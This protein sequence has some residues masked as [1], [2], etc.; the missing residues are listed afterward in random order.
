MRS[1]KKPRAALK[2]TITGQE[3]IDALS[4][5]NALLERML[6]PGPD[7]KSWLVVIGPKTAKNIGALTID[8]PS[9]RRAYKRLCKGERP[10][11]PPQQRE[12]APALF[13]AEGS[14]TAAGSAFLEALDNLR[15]VERVSV[16]KDARFF[17]VVWKDGSF[18]MLKV[19][20]RSGKKAQWK[21]VTYNL[22]GLG[23]M[24]SLPTLE[25]L[26]RRKS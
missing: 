24:D 22:E 12:A 7:G 1:D 19:V 6:R 20:R 11:S 26:A 9:F 8:Y 3:I 10:P 16:S 18:R 17:T 23:L 4:P 13:N 21:D 15:G 2:K 5:Q 14:P 25:E